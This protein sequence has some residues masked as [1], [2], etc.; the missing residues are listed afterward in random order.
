MADIRGPETGTVIGADVFIKG[1][2]S[3]EG[4][5]RLE[6]KFEGKIDS[7]GKLLVG[8]NAQLT[9][10]INAGQVTVEGTLKGNVTGGERVELSAS[11]QVLGD[12]RAPRLVISEGATFVGNCRVSPDAL[13]SGAP[14]AAAANNPAAAQPVRK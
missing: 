10:E 3:F 4:A 12:I 6:G 1:E 9:G 5:M 14:A 7:K 11:A 8:K 13:K 2:L